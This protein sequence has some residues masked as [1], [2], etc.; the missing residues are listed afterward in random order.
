MQDNPNWAYIAEKENGRSGAWE[1]LGAAPPTCPPGYQNLYRADLT[2]QER[3]EQITE[4]VTLVETKQKE[5]KKTSGQIDQTYYEDKGISA[6]S[7]ELGIERNEVKPAVNCTNN[8]VADA[9][10]TCPQVRPVA[11]GVVD[12][13]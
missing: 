5:E 7:R 9:E 3:S 12:Y 13:G 1:A 8:I 6:A 4:W 2:V 10:G 11:G